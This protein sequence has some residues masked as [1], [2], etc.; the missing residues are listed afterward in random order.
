MQCDKTDIVTLLE[1]QGIFVDES[2]HDES[3]EF[4]SLTLVSLIISIENFYSIAI[5]DEYLMH[6]KIDTINKI[7]NIITGLLAESKVR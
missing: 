1:E 7:E 3:L 6:E 4:D 2:N 5:P